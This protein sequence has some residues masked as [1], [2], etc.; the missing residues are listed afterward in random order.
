MAMRTIPGGDSGFQ[1][2][3]SWL[4]PRLN[5]DIF[6]KRELDW[7][8]NTVA[9]IYKQGPFKEKAKTLQSFGAFHIMHPQS[10][11]VTCVHSAHVYHPLAGS[12]SK[13]DGEVVAFIGDRT[14]T[15]MSIPVKL[16]PRSSFEFPQLK[17]VDDPRPME[18]AYEESGGMGILWQPLSTITKQSMK[19]PRML[20]LP[21]FGLK[22]CTPW[23]GESCH[24]N[25]MKRSRP[26]L[27]TQ[28]KQS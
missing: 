27:M 1:Q 10:G 14:A 3:L 4:G 25:S 23:G 2:V 5:D 8:R 7:Q 19:V 16:P 28:A 20:A 13:L 22:F 18:D 15:R 26:T 6:T 9:D 12:P 17:L 11:Y 24:M 21:N